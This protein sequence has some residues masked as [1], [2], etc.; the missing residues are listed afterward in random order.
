MPTPRIATVTLEN[1]YKWQTRINGSIQSIKKYFLNQYWDYEPYPSEKQSRCTNVEVSPP[2]IR[3]M[4]LN[5]ID[6]WGRPLAQDTEGNL[7]CEINLGKGEVEEWCTTTTARE[8][9]LPVGLLDDGD[10]QFSYN[11]EDGTIQQKR[12]FH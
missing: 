8:P 4:R 6:E 2:L 9:N 3:A 7:Y 11:E 10:Y 12:Y 1:G 5:E